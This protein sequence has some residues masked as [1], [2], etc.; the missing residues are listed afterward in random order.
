MELIITQFMHD[1]NHDQQA[2]CQT[3]GQ[4]KNIDQGIDLLPNYVSY[5]NFEK[6]LK[7]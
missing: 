3:Y 1:K 7:H 6:I 4:A 2:A 5:G